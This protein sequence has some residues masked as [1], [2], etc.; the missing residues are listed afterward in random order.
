MD[1]LDLPREKEVY[2]Q[3]NN[4]FYQWH[5]KYFKDDNYQ[6]RITGGGTLPIFLKTAGAWTIGPLSICTFLRNQDNYSIY[7]LKQTPPMF[8]CYQ[9]ENRYPRPLH[10]ESNAN[11]KKELNDYLHDENS[12]FL[13]SLQ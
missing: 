12:W 3:W 6:V 9:L 4:D 7:T 1:I 10:A 5:R 8:K 11:F 2:V 13:I